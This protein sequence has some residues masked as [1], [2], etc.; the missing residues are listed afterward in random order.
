MSDDPTTSSR[1]PAGPATGT[2]D[3][4]AAQREAPRRPWLRVLPWLLSA[5]CFAFLF[6][7]IDGAARAADSRAIPY[8]IG[9]FERVSWGQWL[10]LMIPYSVLYF[11]VESTVIWRV[12]NWFHTEVRFLAILPVRASTYILSILNEQVGKGAMALYLHRRE[13]V[14]G[15]QVGSSMLFLM[16]CEFFYLLSWALIGMSLAENEL[17]REFRILPW[18]AAVAFPALVAFG[19]LVRSER[20]A[21]VALLHSF[22][23]ATPIHY[24]LVILLRSPA[25]IGA[26]FVYAAAAQLFGLPA[27]TLGMLAI[28]PL[29]FFGAA[30]PGPL[31]S[32]AILMWVVFVFPDRPAEATAF[33]LVMHN[34][35]IFF[36]A[37]IGLLFLRRANRDLLEPA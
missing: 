4:D 23:R 17:P 7:R 2:R 24:L 15:W 27:T 13:G 21:G 26:A 33:G 6:F 3:S 34:F 5:A 35:F 9:V 18:I 1:E 14:P 31:R 29:I 28:L 8:L 12:I 32:V 22:R 36:N 20:F 11:L 10:A 37:T 19:F 16:L 30:T 25:M